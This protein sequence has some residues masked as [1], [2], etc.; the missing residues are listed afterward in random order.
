MKLLLIR[1]QCKPSTK[2][3]KMQI[4]Y[5]Y[6]KIEKSAFVAR[7]KMVARGQ[8]SIQAIF[9]KH[10]DRHYYSIQARRNFSTRIGAILHYK[11]HGEKEGLKPSPLFDPSFYR[12]VYPDTAHLP[13][14]FAHFHA[15]GIKKGRLGKLNSN[16]IIFKGNREYDRSLPTVAVIAHELSE[17]GAPILAW[18]IIN[19]IPERWNVVSISLRDGPLKEEFIEK[20]CAFVN[21]SPLADNNTNL[22]LMVD[23]ALKELISR[24]NI[25][26][27]ISN[28]SA[29]EVVATS[30]SNLKIP[31]V[32]LIHEYCSYMPKKTIFNSILYSDCVVFLSK[33][34][35][36]D[37]E[38]TLGFSINNAC[39][40]PQGKSIVPKFDST[41]SGTNLLD[42]LEKE[43]K[44]GK[45]IVIGCGHVQIRKGVDLFIAGCDKIAQT[46][47]RDNVRFVWVGNGY[48]P[49]T[50]HS[51][52]IWLKD[53][54]ERSSLSDCF[55]LIPGL[56]AKELDRLYS[57]ANVM[58][59]SSRLDPL[60]NVA[61]DAMTANIPVVCFAKATGLAEYL[62]DFDNLQHLIAPYLNVQKAAEIIVRLLQ[63]P[64]WMLSI[65]ED[66][67]QLTKTSFSMRHYVDKILNFYDQ[68]QDRQKAIAIEIE[69]LMASGLIEE[70][71]LQAPGQL[72]ILKKSVDHQIRLD[73]VTKHGVHEGVRRPFS[74]FSPHIY[75]ECNNLTLSKSP[76]VDWLRQ[77]RPEGPWKRNVVDLKLVELKSVRSNHKVAIHIHAHYPDQL[78]YIIKE[79][80]LSDCQPDI[81]I[82]S[83]SLKHDTIKRSLSKLYAGKIIFIEV[84]N[85]G[86]D[87][88]PMFSACAEHLLKYEVVGHVHTKKTLHASDRT[89]IDNWVKFLFANCIGSD[90]KSID[91]IVELFAQNPRLG[92]CFPE[93]PNIVGWTENITPAKKLLEDIGLPLDLPNSIEFPVGNM[94]YCR[95]SALAPLFK[96]KFTTSCYPPEP[97]ANDGTMLHAIERLLPLIVE[98]Q[99]FEWI[100]TKIQGLSR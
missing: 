53:Q 60:P 10:F 38:K 1:Q 87:I 78:K 94:F 16:K 55:S 36:D 83:S 33:S 95:P 68:L 76:T 15:R 56:G 6:K 13:F 70:E 5:I 49:D 29:S 11:Q 91:K 79:I 41:K 84:P 39:I 58:F 28:S 48:N 35:L 23:F 3:R 17:T 18:N 77:N 96:R 43:K 12:A 81:I 27:V 65:Q 61:I 40:I 4:K 71:T 30:F 73:W 88:G 8:T 52:S 50:D 72:A 51:Y 97:L 74:G 2:N 85:V 19:N 64:L 7:L 66:L 67:S 32:T 14:L 82:S 75:Y 98:S 44:D 34:I 63:N 69:E 47:G 31:V 80:A 26:Y 22:P 89:S 46:L 9:S 20:S 42:F 25:N 57:I 24:Y 86:R 92:L 93:D 54:I 90:T 100:T 99:D 37:A 62:E 45:F 59:L 21:L